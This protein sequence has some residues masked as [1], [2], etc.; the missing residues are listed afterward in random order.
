[1]LDPRRREVTY[2]LINVVVIRVCT[3]ICGVDDSVAMANAI[4]GAIMPAEF[5]ITQSSTLSRKFVRQRSHD[6]FSYPPLAFRNVDPKTLP[7]R[8]RGHWLQED[9]RFMLDRQMWQTVR[10]DFPLAVSG[11]QR[12]NCPPEI[13]YPVALVV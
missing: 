11:V 2:P 1:M 8:R 13:L 7:V 10:A 6:S 12:Q 3:V 5:E 9:S 4:F